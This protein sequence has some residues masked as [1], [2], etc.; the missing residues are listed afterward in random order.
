MP[1]NHT[2]E[3]LQEFRDV[4]IQYNENRTSDP[5]MDWFRDKDKEG[6]FASDFE[7]VLVILI[8]SRFDQRTTAENALRNTQNVVGYGVLKNCSLALSELPLLIPRQ[9]KTAKDWTELFC[10]ALPGLHKLAE[11]IVAKKR[12]QVD[13]LF[14]LIL[15]DY[16]VPY[17]AVKTSRL[18][19]RWLYELVN[20]L[21][22]DMRNYKI[23]VDSLVYRVASRLGVIDPNV[24]KYYGNSSPAD[25]KI[26]RFVQGLFPEKPWIMDEP[27]W[28]AGRR[29]E[30]GGHCFPTNPSCEGCIFDS[31]CPK[32]FADFAPE[33]VGMQ[34]KSSPGVYN[35]RASKKPSK[36]PKFPTEKQLAFASYV[37]DLKQKGITGERYRE[38][39]AQ[40]QREHKEE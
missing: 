35:Y 23:P 25:L 30:K 16:R 19:V 27:L 3:W 26:Q 31:I 32:K 20:Y 33:S 14:K 8:D 38:M 7:R 9:S 15:F 22:I 37:E 13:D 34:V 4:I 24:D 28:A 39:I 40:W 2:E 12:W 6:F 1:T 18:A 5:F 21:E 36:K 29:K 17:L 11:K 10:N